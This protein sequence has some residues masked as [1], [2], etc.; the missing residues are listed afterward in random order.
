MRSVGRS[1]VATDRRTEC[2]LGGVK[3]AKKQSFGSPHP[4]SLSLRHLLI[5]CNPGG[6][7]FPLRHPHQIV[8]KV[9]WHWVNVSREHQELRLPSATS[10]SGRGRGRTRGHQ[11]EVLIYLLHRAWCSGRLATGVN[12]IGTKYRTN[13]DSRPW[14]LCCS[15]PRS[16]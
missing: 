16:S 13:P 11:D 10:L 6:D 8:Y 2:K 4:R 14:A 9:R 3:E 5:C 1:V 12:S 15:L 7:V